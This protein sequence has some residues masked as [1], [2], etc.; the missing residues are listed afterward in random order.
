MGTQT[1]ESQS[2]RGIC[3]SKGTTEGKDGVV[4]T[5]EAPP[6]TSNRNNIPRQAPFVKT[7]N[8]QTQ[9]S[10]CSSPKPGRR[11]HHHHHHHHHHNHQ[12][13][14]RSH[15]HSHHHGSHSSGR[16]MEERANGEDSGRSSDSSCVSLSRASLEGGAGRRGHSR[17]PECPSPRPSLSSRHSRRH[18]GSTSPASP[19]AAACC[20]SPLLPSHRSFE[21]ARDLLLLPQ[22]S[23]TGGHPGASGRPSS[24]GTPLASRR[25]CHAADQGYDKVHGPSRQRSLDTGDLIPRESSLSGS[26]EA[27]LSRSHSFMQHRSGER[28]RHHDHSQQRSTNGRRQWTEDEDS[29]HEKYLVG[30]PS[31]GSPSGH[32]SVES[33]P[34]SQRRRH[35]RPARSMSER[36]GDAVDDDEERED[37]DEDDKSGRNRTHG[38]PLPHRRPHHHHHH[39]KEFHHSAPPPPTGPPPPLP[40]A[41]PLS[42]HSGAPG[43]TSGGGGSAGSCSPHS[44][45][46]SGLATTGSRASVESSGSALRRRDVHSLHASSPGQQ[47]NISS[48]TSHRHSQGES[49]LNEKGDVDDA[50]EV[51]SIRSEREEVEGR[52]DQRESPP[53][54]RRTT[55]QQHLYSNLDY[56]YVM[57]P[58]MQA[59]LLPLQQYILEQAKLSNCYRFG[60]PV[61]EGER[62]SL[63]S[64]DDEDDEDDDED[65]NEGRR[66]RESGSHRRDDSDEFA[67]DEAMSNQEDSSSQESYYDYVDGG[68]T[69]SLQQFHQGQQ[70]MQHGYSQGST[71][72]GGRGIS[73]ITSLGSHLLGGPSPIPL[74]TQHTSLKRRKDHPAPP[75]PLGHGGQGRQPPPGL[76]SPIMEKAEFQYYPGRSLSPSPSAP[77]TPVTRTL[78]VAVPYPADPV[79]RH[80]YPEGPFCSPIFRPVYLDDGNYLD[81]EEDEREDGRYG[82][83]LGHHVGVALPPARPTILFPASLHQ[84]RPSPSPHLLPSSTSSAAYANTGAS[85]S[86]RAPRS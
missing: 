31:G 61:N 79:L 9:T 44:P 7:V 43:R 82:R 1:H 69:L 65:G 57:G 59:H 15:H 50:S 26:H 41:A 32:R 39:L 12:G 76:C 6:I 17:P 20:P 84:G 81:D 64:E 11:H 13:H 3:I 53:S 16:S 47:S 55:A 22:P 62:D 40:G 29:M 25:T 72:H 74:E 4:V 56:T 10:P 71:G 24:S 8:S 48:S 83:F 19:G 37:E 42:P 54:P 63:H 58:E 34:P 66:G 5:V 33:T 49:R 45:V 27:Q 68:G 51:R 28:C 30:M 78:P 38:T 23:P 77:S 75:P 21:S 70:Q 52:R 2:G 36:H 35:H 73:S 80:T 14:H 46:D 67:D 18:G 85:P 60:D 86:L